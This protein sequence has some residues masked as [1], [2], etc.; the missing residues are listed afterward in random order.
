MK[1]AI[2]ADSHFC[3]SS[4]F[5]ECV[6]IHDWI[7]DD[8]A[9][10]GCTL[11]LHAGDVFERKSTPTERAAV[12]DWEQRMTSAIGQGVIVRG[13]HD[14]P[15]DLPIL[16]R[17]DTGG[18]SVH[19][20]EDA[21]VL[22]LEDVAIA[23]LSWPQRSN[24]HAMLPGSSRDEV[25]ASA[26]DA[27]RS[28]LRGLGEGLRD[29]R[30]YEPCILLAHAMVRGS[31]VSTGQPLTGCDFEIGLEDL[32][33][34]DADFY[35]LGHVHMGNE[36]LIAGAPAV[37]PG[38]PRR[39]AFGEVE[40]KGYLVVEFDGRYLVGWERVETPATPMVLLAARWNG[41]Q[42][43][44]GTTL[45]DAERRG[46]EVRFRYSCPADQRESAKLAAEEVRRDLL[47]LGAAAVKLE[48]QI[49]VQQQARAAAVTKCQSVADKLEVLWQSQGFEPGERRD[50]LVGKAMQIEQQ[51]Q[52]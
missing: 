28:V 30:E 43:E 46:A 24:L 48:E 22:H 11:W 14:A 52:I 29:S 34:V 9:A 23:C 8:A 39:T 7:A 5:E 41:E 36:W 37:Y 25:E 2:V 4:R 15:G 44:G 26:G 1:I 40:P 49:I 12:V 20:V 3:E 10:R 17:I 33:L 13:N 32:A 16:E 45:V 35:A 50:Q 51:V 18:S 27:L 31:R 19:V 21:R 38:S 42:F 47:E 6:R